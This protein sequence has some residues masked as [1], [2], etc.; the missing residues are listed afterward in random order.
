MLFNHIPGY[1][2][3]LA[4]L[5]DNTHL[6][7]DTKVEPVYSSYEYQGLELF[8][9]TKLQTNE[10]KL[11][12]DVELPRRLFKDVEAERANQNQSSLN[13]THSAVL[14]LIRYLVRVFRAENL[15]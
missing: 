5:F 10:G 4:N 8:I 15:L 1:C 2:Y 6:P 9:E 11:Y 3:E 13:T 12:Q 14:S 7:A